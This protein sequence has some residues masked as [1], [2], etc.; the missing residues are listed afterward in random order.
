M[1]MKPNISP[2]VRRLD[3]YRDYKIFFMVHNQ[4]ARTE[5]RI[6]KK[7]WPDY[8]V[9][10]KQ[11]P[12]GPVD[13]AETCAPFSGSIAKLLILCTRQFTMRNS[14]VHF[15]VSLLSF[16]QKIIIFLKFCCVWSGNQFLWESNQ[17]EIKLSRICQLDMG[18]DLVECI[19]QD[20]RLLCSRR[21]VPTIKKLLLLASS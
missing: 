10:V 8:Y 12:P 19:C 1:K 13:P 14:V 17:F 16:L 7:I 4:N 2:S 21:K 3:P 15:L 18:D 9:C 6:K 11:D 20:I 5:D